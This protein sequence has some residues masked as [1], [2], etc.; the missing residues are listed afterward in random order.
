ME[1][2]LKMLKKKIYLSVLESSVSFNTKNYK[3]KGIIILLSA[4]IHVEI[5]VSVEEENN[6][7]IAQINAFLSLALSFSLALY[8]SFSVSF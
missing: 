2:E 5:P 7:I 8:L 4:C 3:K 6:E 1:N